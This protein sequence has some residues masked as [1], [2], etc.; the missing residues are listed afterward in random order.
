MDATLNTLSKLWFVGCDETIFGGV[1]D[2]IYVGENVQPF[3]KD[4]MILVHNDHVECE[5]QIIDHRGELVEPFHLLGN[6]LYL[7]PSFFGKGYKLKIE[8]DM[9]VDL[10]VNYWKTFQD[11]FQITH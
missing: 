7:S 3:I 11:Q 6:R 10:T 5:F 4:E 9:Y 8:N 1:G 2:D